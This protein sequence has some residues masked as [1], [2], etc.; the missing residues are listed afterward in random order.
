MPEQDKT[1]FKY[2]IHKQFND[3]SY[4]RI[5]TEVQQ[6][7]DDFYQSYLFPTAKEIKQDTPQ[8][9][10]EP[11]SKGPVCDI[12]GTHKV[13]TMFKNKEG[14]MVPWWKCPNYQNHPK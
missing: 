9:V 7:F 5:N 1:S 14:K 3:G 13:R 11:E 6:E 2:Q 12:C 8:P 10:S 4:I